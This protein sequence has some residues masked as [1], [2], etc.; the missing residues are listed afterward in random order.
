MHILFG[1]SDFHSRYMYASLKKKKFRPTHPT[2]KFY[3]QKGNTTIFLFGPMINPKGSNLNDIWYLCL[4]HLL[5]ITGQDNYWTNS[6]IQFAGS[7]AFQ[8]ITWNDKIDTK[9]QSFI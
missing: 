8:Y 9:S 6:I 2:L 7:L 3:P 4:S 5:F 1:G